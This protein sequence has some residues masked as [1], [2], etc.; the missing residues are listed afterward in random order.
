LP[1][2][3]GTA[4]SLEEAALAL[5]GAEGFASRERRWRSRER[6]LRLDELAAILRAESDS[7]EA[8]A[9]EALVVELFRRGRLSIDKACELLNVNR[10]TF[11]ERL[12][13]LEIP[14]FLIDKTDWATERSTIEGWPRS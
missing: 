11:A 6:T 2:T 3:E 4:L 7:L 10:E 5:E 8:A 13:D 14:Y 9:R 1:R 12:A